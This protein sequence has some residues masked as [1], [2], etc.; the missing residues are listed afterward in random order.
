MKQPTGNRKDKVDKEENDDEGNTLEKDRRHIPVEA[1]P[2]SH[3]LIIPNCN[4]EA[5]DQTAERKSFSKQS[6]EIA[7]Q[8]K[9]KK[10]NQKD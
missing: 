5:N 4:H 6:L 3:G 7:S 2:G 10:Y 9:E 1:G 8:A